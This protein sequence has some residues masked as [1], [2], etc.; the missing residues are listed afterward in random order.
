[1]VDAVLC[2]SAD[3]TG[4]HAQPAG[5][6]QRHDRRYLG[7]AAAVSARADADLRCLVITAPAAALGQRRLQ[8]EIS[9]ATAGCPERSF[10]M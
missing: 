8:A 1:M 10:A 4:D 6:P 5:Q 7:F 2:R 3:A 9:G